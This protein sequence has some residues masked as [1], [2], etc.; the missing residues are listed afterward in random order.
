MKEKLNIL[1]VCGRNKRRSKTAELIFRDDTRFYARSA[2]FSPNSP[3]QLSIKD[4]VWADTIFV[5]EDAHKSRLRRIYRDPD[6]PCTEVL[7]IEDVYEFMDEELVDL[8]K[9][10]VNEYL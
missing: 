7:Y 6:L 9:T 5:M 1:F 3:H 4:I 10:G 8:L 2:G